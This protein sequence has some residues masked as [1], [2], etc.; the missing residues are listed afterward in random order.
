M[1]W[2]RRD[3]IENKIESC[4]FTKDKKLDTSEKF[5]ISKGKRELLSILTTIVATEYLLD[6]YYL[7]FNNNTT[8]LII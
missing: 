3:N 4:S 2:D 7:W 6:N 1:N 8:L 5:R